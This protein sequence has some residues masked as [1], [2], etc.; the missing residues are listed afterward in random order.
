MKQ[1]K[2][3]QHLVM[4]LIA[5]IILFSCNSS[6]KSTATT[7]P[8]DYNYPLTETYWKLTELMGQPITTEANRKEMFLMLNTEGTRV[9]GNAG[10]NSFMGGYT[11]QEGNRLSFSQLAGTMMAC[12]DMEKEQQF[13]KLLGTVDNYAIKGNAL[14]LHKARMAPLA[15]FEAVVMKK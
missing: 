9:H 3:L 12:P 8:A 14:S 15:R 13:M 5:A 11:L 10:C 1:V 7:L 6:K 4:A 2:N